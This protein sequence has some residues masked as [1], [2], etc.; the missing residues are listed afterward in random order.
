LSWGGKKNISADLIQDYDI[1]TAEYIQNSLDD[2]LG[3]TM[4]FILEAEMDEHLEY[5]PYKHP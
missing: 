3:S 4:Q 5:G 1:K 2:L